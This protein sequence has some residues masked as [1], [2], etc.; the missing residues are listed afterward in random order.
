MTPQAYD[1]ESVTP[2][3]EGDL[4]DLG[5][6]AKYIQPKSMDAMEMIE[7]GRARLESG[8][9]LSLSLSLYVWMGG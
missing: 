5:V 2:F 7:T 6:K 1:F 9:S 3:K 8:R 4:S